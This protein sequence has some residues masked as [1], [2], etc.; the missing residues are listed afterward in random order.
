[1][2]LIPGGVTVG[3]CG[4]DQGGRDLQA[5]PAVCLV[6]QRQLTDSPRLEGGRQESGVISPQRIGVIRE[7]ICGCWGPGGA[8]PRPRACLEGI[9][10]LHQCLC[11]LNPVGE[12]VAGGWD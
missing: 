12:P 11:W 5:T 3:V 7:P 8:K 10:S 6:A 1:M 2:L 4:L 9:P